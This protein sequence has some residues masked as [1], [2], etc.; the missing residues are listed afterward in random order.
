M[1]KRQT[2]RLH[3]RGSIATSAILLGAMCFFQTQSANAR[4]Y[5]LGNGSADF[6]SQQVM[7]ISGPDAE[8]ALNQTVAELHD[9]FARFEPALDSETKI[10]SPPQVSGTEAQ[11]RL[12]VSM[13]KCVFF[14][15]KTVDIDAD[16][17]IHEASGSCDRNLTLVADLARS[18]ELLT[19]TYATLQVSICFKKAAAGAG[20]ITLVAEA[21]H[22]AAYSTGIVQQQLFQTLKLQTSP[23]IAA[24]KQTLDRNTQN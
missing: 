24:L 19:S 23:I 9:V 15:C 14:I 4:N 18:S 20:S 6:I 2:N 8:A 13:E 7:P 22:A 10:I 16:I 3:S 21:T 5:G 12:R 17:S 11:P 1:T